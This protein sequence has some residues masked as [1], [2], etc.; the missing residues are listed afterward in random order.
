MS[1]VAAAI[2][3]GLAAVVLAVL[4]SETTRALALA[5]LP[6]IPRMAVY[7]TVFA[8]TYLA[9]LRLLFPTLL[10]EVVHYLPKSDHVHRFLGYAQAS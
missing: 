10:R 6:P 9:T 8:T 3:P 7:I 2:A 1:G 5:S 4:V